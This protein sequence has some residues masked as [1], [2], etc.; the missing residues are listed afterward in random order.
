MSPD[1]PSNI[2]VF[3]RWHDQTVFAGEEVKCT[4]TFKNVA[5]SHHASASHAS[6]P[7]PTQSR[8]INPDNRPSASAS[9]SRLKSPS[10]LAPPPASRGHRSSLSLT[11]P[12][13]PTTSRTRSGS[14]PWTSQGLQE[15]RQG[16]GHR[17]G[18]GHKR[19]IS[20]VSI[21]STSTVDDGQ[22]SPGSAKPQRP[23]RGHARA[24]S[25]QMAPRGNLLNGPRSGKE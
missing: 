4:I 20:I 8:L 5:R 23:V 17:G 9:Q 3:I 6:K 16:N 14:I 12:S 7:P 18:H 19:S 15:A 21:G 1:G 11:V 13:T 10:A 2:R 22:S 24:S 25:L